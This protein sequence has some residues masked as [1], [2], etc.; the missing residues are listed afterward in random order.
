MPRFLW[1]I[2]ALKEKLI[3]INIYL[4][5]THHTRNR[6]LDFLVDTSFQQV[7]GLFVLSFKDG[8]ESQRQY[9]IPTVEIKD[10]VLVDGMNFFDQLIKNDLKTSDNMR[11]IAID[12]A[13]DYTTGCL[14]DYLYF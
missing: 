2:V 1:V 9:Y 5:P 11:K 7:N 8:G 6:Y 14:L 10:Y 13:D 12:H 4:T 3:G